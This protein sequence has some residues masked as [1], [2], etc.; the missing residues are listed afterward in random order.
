MQHKKKICFIVSSILT[1]KFFLRHHIEKLSSQYEVYLVGNFTQSEMDSVKYFKL[2][3][4]KSI[5]IKRKISIIEDLRATVILFNY[6]KEMKFDAVH[7]LAP[8]AGLISSIAGKL[9][10]IKNRIHIF[11]GQVWHTKKG[12]FKFLL[13]LL[14]KIIVFLNNHILVDGY[15]QKQYLLQNSIINKKKGIVLGKG[16]I[17]GVDLNRFYRDQDKRLAFR[18]QLQIDENDIVFLFLGR[19]NKDKGIVDL[20]KAFNLLLKKMDNVFLLIVGYDENNLIRQLPELIENTNRYKYFGSTDKPEDIMNAG[21]VFVLPSYR[22]GFG[23]SVIE[24]SA[25]ELAIICSDTYGLKDAILENKTGFRHKVGDITSLYNKMFELASN[26]E[27]ITEFG[28]EGLLFIKNNFDAEIVSDNWC[29]FYESL[30][31]N[32]N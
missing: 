24:A 27:L 15:S 5:P 3:G 11:T 17:S 6:Y 18:K 23:T 30:F 9:A 12:V 14:D 28:R 1:A 8:K 29:K 32:Q 26:P 31:I 20:M 21:D 4:I 22:E 2:K 16:S 13:K 10:G 7:S 19:I 25:T